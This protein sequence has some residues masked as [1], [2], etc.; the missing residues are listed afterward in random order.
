MI[1]YEKRIVRVDDDDLAKK[2]ETND[3]SSKEK[4]QTAEWKSIVEYQ[5]KK[6]LQDFRYIRSYKTTY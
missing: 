1:K 2:I 4:L 6:Y 5:Q 3:P